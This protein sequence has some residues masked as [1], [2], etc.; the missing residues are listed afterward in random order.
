MLLLSMAFLN[1]ISSKF[2]A[3]SKFLKSILDKKLSIPLTAVLYLNDGMEA[4]IFPPA[5]ISFDKTTPLS[6]SDLT[7]LSGLVVDFLT[8]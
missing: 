5:S 7:K 1:R 6:L 4:Y 8:A 3:T 2:C